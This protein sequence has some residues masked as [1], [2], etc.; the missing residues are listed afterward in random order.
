MRKLLISSSLVVLS[1]RISVCKRKPVRCNCA[2]GPSAVAAAPTPFEFCRS[3]MNINAFI[4]TV[5]LRLTTAVGE[6]TETSTQGAR[7]TRSLLFVPS[8]IRAPSGALTVTPFS[9]SRLPT[10]TAVRE[11]V[12][13][14]RSVEI[15]LLQAAVS[16]SGK[17]AENRKGRR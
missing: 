9:L 17:Y 10:G 5:A 3:V 16:G 12:T 15:S 7:P 1:L 11:L 14:D 6:I 2:R 4:G 8:R 13:S